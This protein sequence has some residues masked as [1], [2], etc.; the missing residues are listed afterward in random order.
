MPCKYNLQ[1]EDMQVKNPQIADF[2]L[3]RLCTALGMKTD[4]ELAE[5]LGL[6]NKT[7]SGWRARNSFDFALVL[8]KC[9]GINWHWLFTGEGSMYAD[10]EAGRALRTKY[11]KK[12]E[13]LIPL[14]TD[15]MPYILFIEEGD[16][17]AVERF[18]QKVKQAQQISQGQPQKE[19]E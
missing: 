12:E 18:I 10:N 6:S 15:D 4:T 11:D 17:A 3:D 1:Y 19:K 7:L 2:F 13:T 8:E 9:E 14:R 5:F 16:I